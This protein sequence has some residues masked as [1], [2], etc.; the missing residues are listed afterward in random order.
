[1]TVVFTANMDTDFSEWTSETDADNDLSW[2]AS[3]GMAYTAGGCE[4]LIDDTNSM[5]LAKTGLTLAGNLFRY[6][7]YIDPN[8]ICW[9]RAANAVLCQY[10]TQSQTFSILV[11]YGVILAL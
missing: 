2:S 3:A 4:A 5:Y 11:L 10:E 1:M 9:L 8:T 7:I 6:R